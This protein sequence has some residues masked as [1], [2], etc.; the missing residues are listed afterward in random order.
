M[1][2]RLLKFEL[3]ATARTFLP[4]Y[5]LLFLMAVVNKIFLSVNSYDFSIPSGIAM[6]AY[7]SIIIALFVITLI[8][9]I[10]RFYKNLLTDE[11]YLMFTLP[12]SID[13]HIISKLLVAT[14]WNVLCLVLSI[15]SVFVLAVEPGDFARM[16]LDFSELFSYLALHNINAVAITFQCILLVLVSLASSILNLYVSIAI[17]HLVTKHRVAGALG[18]FF[19]ISIIQQIAFTTFISIGE[20]SGFFYQFNTWSPSDM[21]QLVL[22]A[23]IVILVIVSMV[24][25]FITRYILKNKLNLE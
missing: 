25:Y 6:M 18:A 4:L 11:G 8:V 15:F 5:L 1:L 22:V 3:K 13:A 12:A 9:T 14:L 24:Y 21:T 16:M 7:V 10:Q 23:S 20:K 2:R 17:G 19:G